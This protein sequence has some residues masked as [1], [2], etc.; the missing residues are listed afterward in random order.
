MNWVFDKPTVAGSYWYK[1]PA[2]GHD[3]DKDAEIVTVDPEA[4]ELLYA[5]DEVP[6]RLSEKE[7]EFY[8][9]IMHPVELVPLLERVSDA[10]DEAIHSHS[11]VLAEGVLRDINKLIGRR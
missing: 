11:V 5:G 1:N 7:G 3:A 10:L 4:D 8:G 9:P 2:H 6:Y